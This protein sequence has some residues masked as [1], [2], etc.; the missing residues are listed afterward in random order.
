MAAGVNLNTNVQALVHVVDIA[1]LAE[2]EDLTVNLNQQIATEPDPPDPAA[3]NLAH[4]FGND[5]VAMDA[6]DDCENFFILSRGGN[7]VLKAQLGADGKLDI[8]APNDVL[9]LP[10]GQHPDGYR[11]GRRG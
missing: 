10:D 6:D 7:Y 4:L 11:G 9:R 3:G 1:S 5:I 2:R 8:G